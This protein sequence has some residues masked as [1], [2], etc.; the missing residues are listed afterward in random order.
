MLA[1]EVRRKVKDSTMC[2]GKAIYSA[3]D[4]DIGQQVSGPLGILVR[5]ATS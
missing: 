3:Q 1:Y 4:V 2:A 5:A